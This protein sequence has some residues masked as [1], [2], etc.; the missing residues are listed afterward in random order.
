MTHPTRLIACENTSETTTLDHAAS[1]TKDLQ[2]R[3]L[4]AIAKGSLASFIDDEG[5]ADGAR[6]QIGTVA[7][8]IV[9][10]PALHG[11]A[12]RLFA[13]ARLAE[14][15]DDLS[16]HGPLLR[17][18]ARLAAAM[19][20]L[21]PNT[22]GT[23]RQKQAILEA[24][25]HDGWEKKASLLIGLLD[26]SLSVP[27][28]VTVMPVAGAAEI[29]HDEDE[30]VFVRRMMSQA[31]AA[32]RCLSTGHETTAAMLARRTIGEVLAF[33]GG[34]ATT[35]E[36]LANRKQLRAVVAGLFDAGLCPNTNVLAMLDAALERELARIAS[37]EGDDPD[38]HLGPQVH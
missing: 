15:R 31:I 18:G 14:G 4:K 33:H 26:A 22:E 7:A 8:G 23:R 25:R 35:L 36:A 16:S 28:G 30:G 27:D 6:T 3:F 24:I 34:M 17:E 12:I 29:P 13:M 10:I 21:L 11:T 9:S 2:D 1:L 19:V 37:L 20:A 32:H 38:N 5:K